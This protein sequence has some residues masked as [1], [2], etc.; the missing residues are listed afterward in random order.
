MKRKRK[1][2]SL[3]TA[4]QAME[5]GREVFAVPGSILSETSKG[6]NALIQQGAKLVISHHDILEELGSSEMIKINK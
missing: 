2:G 3:I 1:V 6:T 4:D 5:Q